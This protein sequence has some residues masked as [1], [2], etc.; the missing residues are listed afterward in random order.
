MGLPGTGI[1][2]D[3]GGVEDGLFWLEPDATSSAYA[4]SRDDAWDPVMSF[5]DVGRRELWKTKVGWFLT[6]LR[7]LVMFASSMRPVSAECILS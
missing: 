5:P 3:E 7:C 4:S 1:T 6:V 2:G